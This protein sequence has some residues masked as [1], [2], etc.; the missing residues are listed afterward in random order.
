MRRV[1]TIKDIAQRAGVSVSTA[2]RALNDNPRISQATR[3]KVKQVV[4][5]YSGQLRLYA[6]AL[7]IMQPR[8][9][10]QMGLYLLELNEFVSIQG[11]GEQSG[12]H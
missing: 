5:K 9:V 1:A 4:Q 10:V 7:N 11:R 12:N 3:L 6:E 8:P 2:S